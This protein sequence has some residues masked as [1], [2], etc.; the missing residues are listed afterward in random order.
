MNMS[1]ATSPYD[2]IAKVPSFAVSSK[3]IADG[4]ELPLAQVSGIFGAGGTDTSP[5]LQWSGF[6]GE[7]R[8]FV[9][10]VYDPLAPT[11][12]GFWHWAVV[13]IPAGV[14]QLDTGAGDAGG[15]GIPEGAFQLR[16]DAGLA[17]YL[18]AAPPAG[19]GKHIYYVGVHAVDV[20]S[21]NL[22]HAA[23]PAFLGFNLSSHTLARGVM[24][25]WWEAK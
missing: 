15:S 20:A 10:T 16:N 4:G 3:D 21:L 18:G 25:P 22:D 14:T 17:Q 23:T 1:T 2:E 6:P 5:Q 19:S 11:G 24:K 12:S 7:T 13:D 9:V 8:S